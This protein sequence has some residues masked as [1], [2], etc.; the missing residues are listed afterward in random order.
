MTAAVW[1][2]TPGEAY[3]VLGVEGYDVRCADAVVELPDGATALTSI[4]LCDI[5][6]RRSVRVFASGGLVGSGST[7]LMSDDPTL[8]TYTLPAGAKNHQNIVAALTADFTPRFTD[9]STPEGCRCAERAEGPL[10][11]TLTRVQAP[12]VEEAPGVTNF[13]K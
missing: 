3:P 4:P 6:V 1:R 7:P 2:P 12:D 10:T 11:P 13:P 9:H 8:C 5:E